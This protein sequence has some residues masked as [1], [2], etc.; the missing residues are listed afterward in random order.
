[1]GIVVGV[2]FE[3]VVVVG[4]EVWVWVWG[5]VW[6]GVV[7]GVWVGVVVGV[8]VWGGVE[9]G[10]GVVVGVECMTS[11]TPHARALEAASYKLS[12]GVAINLSRGICNTI[13]QTY[14]TTLLDS[15]EMEEKIKDALD[16]LWV[17]YAEVTMCQSAKTVIAAI[18]KEAGL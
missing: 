11:Q 10:V 1:M 8:E 17:E 14:L 7:V 2:G 4:F 12:N 6:V 3:F 5:E 9:G 16:E 13:V 15:P 18:K